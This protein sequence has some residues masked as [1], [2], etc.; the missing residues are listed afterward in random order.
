MIWFFQGSFCGGLIGLFFR[1]NFVRARIV[2]T[3]DDLHGAFS[4]CF[5]VFELLNLRLRSW[6]RETGSHLLLQ[7]LLLLP[8]NRLLYSDFG[9]EEIDFDR[10]G[11]IVNRFVALVVIVKEVYFLAFL[12]LLRLHE[13]IFKFV[14]MT[15]L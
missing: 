8:R 10:G 4:F 9:L 2:A 5:V 12:G 7:G 3:I 13:T 11:L 6:L 1:G 14:E 15:N